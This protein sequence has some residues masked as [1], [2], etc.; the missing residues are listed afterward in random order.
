MNKLYNIVI[1]FIHARLSL[2]RT[3]EPANALTDLTGTDRPAETLVAQGSPLTEQ[4]DRGSIPVTSATIKGEKGLD[5]LPKLP[6]SVRSH[7]PTESKTMNTNTILTDRKTL[8]AAALAAVPLSRATLERETQSGG[9]LYENPEGVPANIL[10]NANRAWRD[11]IRTLSAVS[12]G[13]ADNI[14]ATLG[15]VR[16]RSHKGWRYTL[17]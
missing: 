5:F 6:Y 7:I 2:R 17:I 3:R 1:K 13:E 9:I 14:L 15:V 16:T 4:T 12:D 11:L 10:R 8:R